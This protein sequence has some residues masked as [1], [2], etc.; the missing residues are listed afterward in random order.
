M[1]VSTRIL[2]RDMFSFCFFSS[3][4][5]VGFWSSILYHKIDTI[6]TNTVALLVDT[7]VTVFVV[8]IGFSIITEIVVKRLYCIKTLP[9]AHKDEQLWKLLP[10]RSWSFGFILGVYFSIFLTYLFDVTYKFF[11][12][13]QITL[14]QFVMIKMIYSSILGGVIAILT[15]QRMVPI[16]PEKK[17]EMEN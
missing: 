10:N 7:F 8:C 13:T 12:W 2:C 9:P 11:D 6:G 1:H 4:S 3:L 14:T 5:L 16:K 17:S 15:I